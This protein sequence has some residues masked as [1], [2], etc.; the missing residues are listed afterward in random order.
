MLFKQCKILHFK[1]ILM[2]LPERL[3]KWRSQWT[4]GQIFL[5]KGQTT[6][7][8]KEVYFKLS[9][10]GQKERNFSRALD[11]TSSQNDLEKKKNRN[12]WRVLSPVEKRAPLLTCKW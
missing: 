7:S 6:I 2:L 1:F 11:K 8:K 3:K 5:T 10:D 4:E 12:E 9:I